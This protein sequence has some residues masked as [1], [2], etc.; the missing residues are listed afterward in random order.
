MA[1]MSIG[2]QL[3][4]KTRQNLHDRRTLAQ[5]WADD[6]WNKVVE[7]EGSKGFFFAFTPREQKAIA[8]RETGT[9]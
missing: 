2:Q 8:E 3:G 9:E 7:Y 1:S 5:K 4:R 6:N